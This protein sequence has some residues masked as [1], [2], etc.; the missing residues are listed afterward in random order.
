MVKKVKMKVAQ[1]CRNLCNPMDYT[2]YGIFQA[3]IL[4][5]GAIPFSRVS[6]QP[7]DRTQVFH[8]AGGFFTSWATR[9]TQEYWKKRKKESEVTQSCSIL[10]DPVDCS[11]SGSSIRGIFQAGVLEWVAISFSR[12]SSWPRGETQVSHIAGRCF[13]LWA[14][15]E[16]LW[17]LEWVAYPFSNGS[18]QSRDWTHCC[19]RPGFNPWIEKIHWRRKWQP[20]PVF[21]PGEFHG[22][23]S[24][25]GYSPWG[26]KESDITE[27]LSLSLLLLLLLLDNCLFLFI[28]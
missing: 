28:Y 5:W 20:T 15:R 4:E 9:E 18:S 24:L 26:H 27:W 19:N 2:V 23:R 21:L 3:T 14:T 25:V 1:S 10:W 13:T 17:V 7:R 8:I 11:L 16:A 6:S 22:Q 12:G